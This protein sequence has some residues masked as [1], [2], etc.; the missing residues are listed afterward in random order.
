MPVFD[1]SFDYKSDK[2]AKTKPDADRD[3]PRLRSDHEL[4]W[5]KKLR[6]GVLFAP[7]A[8]PA[9]RDGYLIFT[10]TSGARHWYGSDAITSSHTTWLRPKAL[11][12]AIASLNETQRSRYLNQPYTIGSSMIWP[13]RSK[14]RPTMNTARG[15]G[16][17][18]RLIADRMDL[19]LECIRRHYTGEPESPL[20]SVLNAYADF[21]ALFDGFAEFVDFFHLQDLVTPDYDEVR[22]YLP[23]DNFERSG[24]PATTAEYVTYREAALEFI[25]GRARRMAKWV[26]EHHPEIEVRR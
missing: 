9:R 11:V 8:P 26:L 20:T 18:G 17:S 16:P 21:F 2:P 23:F 24:A 3:S 10:D 13:V 7:T 15:F 4:L 25:A 22:F 12:D 5:S 6:S 14:D 1:T 19:T